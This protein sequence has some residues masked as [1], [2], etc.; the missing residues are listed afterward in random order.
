MVTTSGIQDNMNFV[1]FETRG[2]LDVPEFLSRITSKD[3]R[4]LCLKLKDWPTTDDFAELQPKRFSDLMSNLP[5]PDYTRRDG[6]LNLAARLASFFVCPD[7]GP[8][9]TTN[10]HVDIADAVNVM[11]CVGQ[12]ID[13]SK[14][15]LTNAENVLNTLKC[16]RVD[17]SYLDRTV[18][19]LNRLKSCHNNNNN[20]NR[21]FGFDGKITS[22]S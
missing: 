10:L 11:L 18:S 7:L 8:K 21:E 13:S 3:G 5:M 2:Q 15:M 4:A 6:Q 19:W 12:P 14:D 22:F 20:N 17:N 9:F 1:L 16:S